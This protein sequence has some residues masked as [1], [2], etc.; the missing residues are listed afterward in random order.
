M[1]VKAHQ[2]CE[3]EEDYAL[4]LL[5]CVNRDSQGKVT[6]PDSSPSSR[7]IQ[8]FARQCVSERIS[9]LLEERR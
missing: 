7:E 6:Q 2:A 3:R 1:D 5:P 8:P 4:A 9:E